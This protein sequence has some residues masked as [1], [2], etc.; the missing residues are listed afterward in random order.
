MSVYLILLYLGV[1]QISVG[2]TTART[3]KPSA[4]RSEKTVF[5][6]PDFDDQNSAPGAAFTADSMHFRKPM[7]IQPDWKPMEFYVKHCSQIDSRVHY[8]KTSYECSFQF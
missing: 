5:W 3:V 1:L 6:I 2:C 8:S 7:P 4:P